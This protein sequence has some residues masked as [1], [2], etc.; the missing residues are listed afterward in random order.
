MQIKLFNIPIGASDSDV[1]EMNHFLRAN[2]IIDI[3]KE[4]ATVSGNSCWSFCVT[5][6]ISNHPADVEQGR[7]RVNAKVDYKDVLS[8]EVFA[9]FSDF[10]KLRK[11]IADSEA[12]PAY[13]VF[14]DAE[15][16][17]IAKLPELTF[18]AIGKI[19]GIGKR[20]VEKYAQSFMKNQ[21]TQANEASR[22]SDGID[23]ESW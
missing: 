21:N 1:E 16:A 15:L 2:K 12:I 3:K 19:P 14:T 17:E 8:P 10:R 6:M 5:Y 13:A 23:S 9:K 20:K 22:G 4:L 18:S 7:Q 11:Q